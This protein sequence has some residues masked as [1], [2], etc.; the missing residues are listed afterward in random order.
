M[1]IAGR[2]HKTTYAIDTRCWTASGRAKER[3][4]IGICVIARRIDTIWLSEEQALT[5]RRNTHVSGTGIT[6]VTDERLHTARA[7][8]ALAYVAQVVSSAIIRCSTCRSTFEVGEA[9]TAIPF[10]TYPIRVCASIVEDTIDGR[11]NTCSNGTTS[12]QG[13]RETIA[14]FCIALAIRDRAVHGV[15]RNA[16][17]V[18]RTGDHIARIVLASDTEFVWYIATLAVITRISRAVVAVITV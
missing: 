16:G 7:V 3:A 10:K 15:C 12:V 4:T 13:A 18:E 11:V 14:A 9:D 1:V 17:T 2:V 5:R 8:S 6:I